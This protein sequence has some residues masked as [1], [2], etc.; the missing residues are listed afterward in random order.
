VKI[1]TD[2]GASRQAWSRSRISAPSL[3]HLAG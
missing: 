2:P 3:M 1:A